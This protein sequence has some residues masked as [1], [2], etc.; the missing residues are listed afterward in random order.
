MARRIIEVI[1]C[2]FCGAE[3]T[4]E[5]EPLVTKSYVWQGKSYETDLCQSDAKKVEDFFDELTFHSR[6]VT[7]EGT[8]K[9]RRRKPYSGDSRFDEWKNDQGKYECPYTWTDDAGEHQCSRRG[10]KGFDRPNGL[11]V[12]HARQH[13]ISL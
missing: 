1:H 4:A 9:I 2:D 13:G 3:D 8:T 6:R 10:D 7:D 5:S 12:H 11:A